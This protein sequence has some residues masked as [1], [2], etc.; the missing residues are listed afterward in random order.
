MTLK[1]V[2][3]LAIAV[4]LLVCNANAG[5]PPCPPP[6]PCDPCDSCCK[7]C[8]PC[9]PCDSC[10][11]PCKKCPPGTECR[12]PC[13]QEGCPPG[14]ECRPPCTTEKCPPGT[15]CRGPCP[16]CPPTVPCPSP[17]TADCPSCSGGTC[18]R[19]HLDFYVDNELRT[20]RL[21]GEVPGLNNHL[22]FP[23][24]TQ[25]V[26]DEVRWLMG[27]NAKAKLYCAGATATKTEYAYAE[28]NGTC[29]TQITFYVNE[30]LNSIRRWCEVPKLHETIE[31]PDGS[32]CGIG[33]VL[34]HVDSHANVEIYC[35]VGKTTAAALSVDDVFTDEESAGLCF[36]NSFKL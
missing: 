19:V 3:Y 29:D 36:I 18:C 23:G 34:W 2:F 10:C 32:L 9:D 11:P 17:K 35:T 25:C 21:W 12:P 6:P 13:I 33:K 14:T 16:K 22:L 30:R 15:E 26:V 4:C 1:K 27:N 5:T 24:G 8:E 7:E 20:S 31:L 28:S